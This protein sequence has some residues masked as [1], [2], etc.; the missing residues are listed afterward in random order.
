MHIVPVIDQRP[1]IKWTGKAAKKAQKQV[2]QKARGR[3]KNGLLIFKLFQ[4]LKQTRQTQNAEFTQQS[5]A[6]ACHRQV[7]LFHTANR[8]FIGSSFS[9][10]N[11][12]LRHTYF[13]TSCS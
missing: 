12:K 5:Q 3:R 11:Y 4:H 1:E 6:I 9:N 10:G 13:L 8:A 2:L 7:H